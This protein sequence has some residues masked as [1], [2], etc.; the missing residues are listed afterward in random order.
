MNQKPEQPKLEVDTRTIENIFPHPLG[1]LWAIALDFFEKANLEKTLVIF[2]LVAMTIICTLASTEV[3]ISDPLV[4]ILG[5]LKS[6]K[7]VDEAVLRQDLADYFSNIM[8]KPDGS[9][10]FSL[11]LKDVEQSYPSFISGDPYLPGAHS[12]SNISIG[13]VGTEN[14]LHFD[15]SPSEPTLL[16]V[17]NLL[18]SAKTDIGGFSGKVTLKSFKISNEDID[19]IFPKQIATQIKN[20]VDHLTCNLY[21]RLFYSP[22]SATSQISNNYSILIGNNIN[23]DYGNNTISITLSTDY[24]LSPNEVSVVKD[25]GATILSEAVVGPEAELLF[26]KLLAYSGGKVV[27]P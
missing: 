13:K 2:Y 26:K 8:L 24:T 12:G 11:Y 21:L 1:A 25:K 5:K 22:S 19:K 17:S 3:S 4:N 18:Q 6:G 20:Q 16:E 9:A 10:E 27:E 14:K 15:L 23:C 7:Y